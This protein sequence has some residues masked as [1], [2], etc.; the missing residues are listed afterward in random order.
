MDLHTTTVPTP[1]GPFTLLVGGDGVCAAGFTGR[2]EDLQR[3][4]DPRRRAAV[5]RPATDPD[6]V[7]SRMLAYLEG[8]AGALDE[9]VVAQPGD[10]ARQ[11]AWRALR[12]VPA[13]ETISYKQLGAMAGLADPATDPLGAQAAGAACAGNHVAVIVPCHRVV[14][15]DGRLGGYGW[16]LHR[17]SWLLDFESTVRAPAA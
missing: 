5:V 14:R 3:R 1:V 17:K 2:P 9:I 10:P 15:T 12:T 8:E 11:D 4:L 13:G 6:G 16:G 7:A